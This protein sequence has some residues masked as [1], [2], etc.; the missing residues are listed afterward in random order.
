MGYDGTHVT[1]REVFSDSAVVELSVRVSNKASTASGVEVATTVHKFDPQTGTSGEE[2]A[3]SSRSPI[4][5]QAKSSDSANSSITIQNPNLWSPDSLAVYVAITRIYSNGTEVDTYETRFGIRT[6]TYD[7]HQG[8]SVNGEHIKIQG[9]NQHHDL[10]ALGA[11]FNVRAAERQLEILQEM[12]VNT[13]RLSHDPPASELLDLTDRMGFLVMDEIFDSWQLNKTDNDFHLI[14]DDWHEADLRAMARRDRNH[15]SIFLWSYGNEVGEQYTNE[16]GAALSA[17]LR[18]ILREEDPTRLSSAS[19]NY[20]TPDLPWSEAVDLFYLNYHGAGIRNTEAYGN[21]SGIF[22]QP[23]YPDYHAK[24]PD[25]MIPSSETAS[26]LSTRETTSFLLQ[27]TIPRP[28]TI[29]RVAT[30]PGGG[31]VTTACTQQT[32]ALRQLKTPTLSSQGNPSGLASTISASRRHTTPH[33]VL[34]VVSWI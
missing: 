13:I 27:A 9:V 17:S 4:T 3:A 28:S 31:S 24:F 26:T 7:A 20:A 19:Q 22:T 34:T 18:D 23:L 1:T 25:K 30:R 14:F 11:A 10:G 21:M 2:V 16:T 12:G 33:V 5:V 6:I 8:L 32:S 15:P 29:R